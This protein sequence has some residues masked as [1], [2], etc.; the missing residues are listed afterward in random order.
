MA[1]PLRVLI[2]EDSIDD[3]ALLLYEL[4]RGGYE[5]THQRVDTPEGLEQA[6]ATNSW[7]IVLVDFTMPRFSGRK[8]LE[9]VKARDTYLPFIFVSGTI[10]EDA[11][12]AAMKS[13]AH[14]Y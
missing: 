5:A 10:G 13:G 4:K 2:V 7:D 8:A 12:V 9:M 14:D 1:T 3:A 6:F 11:A